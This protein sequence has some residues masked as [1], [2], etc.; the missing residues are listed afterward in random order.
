M[1]WY[2]VELAYTIK[3][4]VSV[5]EAASEVDAINKAKHK[6]EEN[7][8]IILKNENI[9]KGEPVFDIV[10]HIQKVRK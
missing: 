3:L 10:T 7:L 2:D 9:K 4:A 5:G 8:E 6:V 1:D